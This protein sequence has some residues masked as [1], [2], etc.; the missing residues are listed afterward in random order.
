MK[1]YCFFFLFILQLKQFFLLLIYILIDLHTL[2]S[3][4]QITV[5]YVK[6][7]EPLAVWD[8]RRFEFWNI[9]VNSQ[10]PDQKSNLQA[11]D[12]SRTAIQLE[13]FIFKNK[14]KFNFKRR[15]FSPSWDNNRNAP[16]ETENIPNSRARH[17]ERAGVKKRID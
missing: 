13:R 3:S 11:P 7:R 12:L 2:R 5:G 16:W 6:S 8:W 1:I 4:F 9:F 17:I 14:R 15:I 10:A